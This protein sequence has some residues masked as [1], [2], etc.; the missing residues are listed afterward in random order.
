MSGSYKDRL[1][2]LE[3]QEVEEEEDEPDIYASR[4]RAEHSG[5]VHCMTYRP[6]RETPEGLE[7]T[8][9]DGSV[10]KQD[11]ILSPS[12]RGAKFTTSGSH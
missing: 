2:R 10:E 3:Q 8:N 5:G 12:G 1:Q 4:C 7:F 11:L 6:F 9:C